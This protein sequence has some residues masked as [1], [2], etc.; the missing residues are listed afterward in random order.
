[1][2]TFIQAVLLVS[3]LV[4][5]GYAADLRLPA[6]AVAGTAVSIQTSGSGNATFY[7]VG[8]AAR[9]KR[10]VQLGESIKL[11]PEEVRQAGR[12]L[13]VLRSSD[14]ESAKAFFV[15]PAEPVNINFLAQPSRVPAAKRGVI[16]GTAFVLDRFDNLVLAPQPVKFELSVG[17]SAP[18]TRTVTSRD[19]VAWTRMDSGRRAGAAQFVVSSGEASVRRV[20][21]QVA[22][23][24]CNLRMR[25]ERGK[26]GIVVETDPVRDCAGNPVPDG[27]I[28][29]FTATDPRGKSTVDARVK[30]GI[31]RAEFPPASTATITVASG[32]V[33]GN[34]IHWGGGR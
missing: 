19:G 32:V 17:E 31:A 24:P 28:V 8:P 11:Q 21:Q 33:M 20:V 1:M 22:A 23:D 26:E 15:S 6:Q 16:T 2:R 34:E 13:A 29:T 14:G 10:K 27:T 30:K 12:Y 3:V 4:A 7:L 18:V 5:S 25:A 9:I